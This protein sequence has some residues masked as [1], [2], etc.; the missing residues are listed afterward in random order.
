MKTIFVEEAPGTYR[1]A[2][3][4][5][6][7]QAA[8]RATANQFRRGTTF[9][10]PSRVRDWAMLRL[11][12]MEREV[13]AVAYLDSRNRLIDFIIEFQGTLTQT[14]V[15]PRELMKNALTKGARSLVLFHNHPSGTLDPSTAD[16]MLTNTILE[17]M[18]FIDVNVLDHVI[19][20]HE[21]TYSFAEHG[22]I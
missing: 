12:P 4:D 5:E 21:G 9:D 6:L 18:R 16:R 3:K 2:T 13:F 8:L 1:I 17:S 7:V 20:S 15:Y 14:S 11:G 22:L 19:V 10:S